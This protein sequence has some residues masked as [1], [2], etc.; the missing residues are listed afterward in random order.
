VALQYR[1]HS[2]LLEVLNLKYKKSLMA[3][4]IACLL[5]APAYSMPNE[6]CYFGQA[7]NCEFGQHMG[8]HSMGLGV[9]F[10]MTDLTEEEMDNMT[11]GELEQLREDE[12]E[13]LNNMTLGELKSLR[14]DNKGERKE[15]IE[16][17]TLGE[18]KELEKVNCEEHD[19]IGQHEMARGNHKGRCHSGL[20]VLF[21]MTD[22]TEEEMDNMTFG[23][24]KDLRENEMKNMENMTLGELK[25]LREENKVEKMD[26]MENMTLGEFKEHRKENSHDRCQMGRGMAKA[27]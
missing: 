11:L 18:M 6:K 24:L 12:M 23:E 20:G 7:M 10:F 3:L 1:L 13:K 15:S 8:G 9:L 14:E 2:C 25:D 19:R 21:F 27:Y 4:A 22:L 17:M 26:A 16:N 5:A